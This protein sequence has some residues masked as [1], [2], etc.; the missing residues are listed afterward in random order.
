MKEKINAVFF[1]NGMRK[2]MLD[3]TGGKENL[4]KVFKL[5]IGVDK[6]CKPWD[7]H[8]EFDDKIIDGQ[9]F[10]EVLDIKDLKKILSE[11]NIQYALLVGF[12]G[13]LYK[14]S[15]KI[16]WELS[17]RNIQYGYFENRT[18]LNKIIGIKKTKSFTIR[19]LAARVLKNI[20]VGF[21]RFFISSPKHLFTS[22]SKKL[23]FL[24][25]STKLI[26]IPHREVFIAKKQPEINPGYR[27]FVYLHQPIRQYYD[28]ETSE[29][30]FELIQ[31]SI[32]A[33]ARKTAFKPIVCLHPN[34]KEDELDYFKQHF[35]SKK[36]KTASFC[37][38]AEFLLGH[39]SISVNYGYIFKKPAALL[40][41]E[42]FKYRNARVKKMA[43]IHQLPIVKIQGEKLSYFE[44]VLPSN[45]K[46]HSIIGKKFD[47]GFRYEEIIGKA[48][49]KMDQ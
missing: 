23:L 7:Y 33:I 44:P 41:L 40:D 17:K 47:S 28:K 11:H 27:Y 35:F 46:I 30:I 38:N 15:T 42:H 5:F 39:S 26:P 10:F 6:L 45:K 31:Q 16:I 25:K 8:R 2:R 21:F 49:Q 13:A 18:D 24:N 37:R 1:A 36:G 29:R 12:A 9:K 20:Y 19:A 48:I 32:S 14:K 4:E 3:E 43:E 22:Y 34:T